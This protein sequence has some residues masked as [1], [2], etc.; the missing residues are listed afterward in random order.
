ML[1]N[2]NI[3]ASYKYIY[4]RCVKSTIGGK[5]YDKEEDAQTRKVYKQ[6]LDFSEFLR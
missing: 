2:T 5:V 4:D 3:N 1:I 6:D